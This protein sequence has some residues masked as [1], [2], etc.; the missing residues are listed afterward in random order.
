MKVMVKMSA[1]TIWLL[2]LMSEPSSGKHG[3]VG[4]FLLCCTLKE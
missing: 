4:M 3:T 1:A 2:Y